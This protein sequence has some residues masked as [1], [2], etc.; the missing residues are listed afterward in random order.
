MSSSINTPG[1]RIRSKATAAPEDKPG[2]R[3]KSDGAPRGTVPFSAPPSV[4]MPRAKTEL[5]EL[6]AD[7]PLLCVRR[8]S[9]ARSTQEFSTGGQ[10]PLTQTQAASDARPPVED[11]DLARVIEVWP[12]L[13]RSIRA[14]IV[15]L[16]RE[17]AK[18]LAGG[19]QA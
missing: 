6:L 11:A 13:P 8:L 10:Q 9:A 1:P 5:A 15:A 18:S 4:V 19:G 2:L 7:D 12:A 17:E 14:A 3:A 16:V